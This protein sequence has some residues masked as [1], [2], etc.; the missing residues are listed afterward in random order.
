M[1]TA[2]AAPTLALTI[3]AVVT[4]CALLCK[5]LDARNTRFARETHVGL[6]GEET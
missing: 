6:P 1:T 5:W 4:G 2:T 3:L